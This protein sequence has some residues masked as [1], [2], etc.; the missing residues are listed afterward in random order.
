MLTSAWEAQQRGPVEKLCEETV[1]G[2]ELRDHG[3]EAD[4]LG[5]C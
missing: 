3:V 2:T 5:S 4:S 1:L